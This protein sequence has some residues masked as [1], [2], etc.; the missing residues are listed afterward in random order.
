MSDDKFHKVRFT[1]HEIIED[2]NKSSA[3]EDSACKNDIQNFYASL[4]KLLNNKKEDN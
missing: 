1:E 2:N 3:I 4:E